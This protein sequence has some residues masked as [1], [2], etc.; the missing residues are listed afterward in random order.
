M[1]K[2]AGVGCKDFIVDNGWVATPAIL[3]GKFLVGTE[4]EGESAHRIG[5][6][7]ELC[8]DCVASMHPKVEVENGDSDESGIPDSGVSP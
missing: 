5:D 2:C 6:S 8:V 1:I 4:G 7:V 3:V